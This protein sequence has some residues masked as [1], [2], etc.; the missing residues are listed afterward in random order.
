MAWID[1][2]GKIHRDTPPPT[3]SYIDDAGRIHRVA[4]TSTP[5]TPIRRTP[6][7][8]NN[9]TVFTRT[10]P[11]E[12][13]RIY[14]SDRSF[15]VTGILGIVFGLLG[16]HNFYSK[17]YKKAIIQLCV[18][19]GSLLLPTL[20]GL[21]VIIGIWIWGIVEGVMVLKGDIEEDGE[22]YDFWHSWFSNSN[23]TTREYVEPYSYPNI[24]AWV[25]T[26]IASI[27]WIT[28]IISVIINAST[29][30]TTTSTSGTSI[31]PTPPVDLA[32]QI[33]ANETTF[34]RNGNTFYRINNEGVFQKWNGNSKT[35]WE[36]IDV[37]V[38]SI[39]Q[40]GNTT[41]YIKTDNSLWGY[42]KN[43][44]GALGNGTGV[45]IESPVKILDNAA[46]VYKSGSYI[47]YALKNDKTLWMW[48]D[49]EKF[50]PELYAE[51]IVDL[52]EYNYSDTLQIS[53]GNVIPLV[54][55]NG[56]AKYKNWDIPVY[57]YLGSLYTKG[58]NDK[59]SYKY[60]YVLNGYYI[61]ENNILWHSNGENTVKLTDNVKSIESDDMCRHLFCIKNDN[62]LWAMGDNTGGQ[63]GDKT[64]VPR[65]NEL[66]K[67]ADNIKF[68]SRYYY[69]TTND[70]LWLWNMDT[71]TPSHFLSDVAKIYPGNSRIN[72]YY[73]D[74]GAILLKDGTLIYDISSWQNGKGGTISNVKVP[75]PV[76]SQIPENAVEFGNHHY[77]FYKSGISWTEADAEAKKLGGHLATISSAEENA[78]ILEEGKK[79]DVHFYWL[80]A[81]SFSGTWSWVTG[82]KWEFT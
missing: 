58:Y 64:K 80:G 70:E 45:D 28:I 9:S 2:E 21:V 39:E 18:T 8:T 36:N 16:I 82:E 54:S 23:D 13:R 67:I 68:A 30:S 74:I 62:T 66:V 29:T 73:Y 47:S 56:S 14:H 71:P 57:D 22:G 10:P 51:D 79:Y 19:L 11:V 27:V 37:D 63:L 42:G 12:R 41:F 4:E 78:F 3:G 59:G 46:K 35:E 5:R 32:L 33:S 48:G 69:L 77:M 43:T 1:D 52:K 38:R 81:N 7:Q 15:L 72:N 60:K 31:Q 26:S 76:K 50:K 24:K 34:V 49:G 53:N 55:E 17:Y 40:V 6:F 44:Q 75:T 25:F 20:L 61:D 65:D